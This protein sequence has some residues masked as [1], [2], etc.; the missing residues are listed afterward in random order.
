MSLG[1]IWLLSF[2]CRTIVHFCLGPGPIQ[3][4]VFNQAPRQASWLGLTGQ[5]KRILCFLCT[6]CLVG[7]FFYCCLLGFLFLLFLFFSFWGRETVF[8]F[9]ELG[10]LCCDEA[11]RPRQL[12]QGR[13]IL[14]YT[15]RWSS[16]TEESQAKTQTGQKHRGVLLTC[17]LPCLAQPRDG[18]TYSEPDLPHQRPTPSCIAWSCAGIFLIEVPSSHMILATIKLT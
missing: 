18:A 11:Q 17:L 1:V 10:L 16:T 12:G 15:C 13:F 6:F 8:L 3:S 5:H 14:A 2:L 7:F 4:L 9:W